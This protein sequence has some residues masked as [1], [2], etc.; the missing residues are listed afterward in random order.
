MVVAGPHSDV[1]GSA[2]APH[3]RLQ[4]AQT[5]RAADGLVI[6][7]LADLPEDLDAGIAAMADGKYSAEEWIEDISVEQVVPVFAELRKGRG[8]KV[9]VSV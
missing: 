6:D 9:L 5:R 3:T 2:Q 8:M 1:G 4:P 7:A